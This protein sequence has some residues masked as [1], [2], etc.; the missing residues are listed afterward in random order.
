MGMGV[1]EAVRA[2][3]AGLC[4]QCRMNGMAWPCILNEEWV[5]YVQE[6]WAFKAVWRRCAHFVDTRY[7]GMLCSP[8]RWLHATT[9]EKGCSGPKRKPHHR[10]A[11]RRVTAL[12]HGQHPTF[13][14][15]G[16]AVTS[17]LRNT[18][19]CCTFRGDGDWGT[20]FCMVNRWR[21]VTN[22]LSHN[23]QSLPRTFAQEP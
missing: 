16:L 18:S 2:A 8:Q 19:I 9:F 20:C 13:T 10:E 1:R 3:S 6:E 12:P 7:L 23:L 15:R 14:Q 21:R 11:T 4:E 17:I 5:S 22:Q